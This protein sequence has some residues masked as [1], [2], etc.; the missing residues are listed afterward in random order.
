MH[1]STTRRQTIAALAVLVAFA[2]MGPCSAD[3]GTDDVALGALVNGPQRSEKNRARDR[4]RHPLES[5][6]FV[7]VEPGHTVIEI[8]PGSGGFWTEILAPY[9]RERGRYVAAI[10]A[11][12]TASPEGRK[13]N[14]ALR[15]KLAGSPALYDRV[16][17]AELDPKGTLAV[18]PGSADV[19]LTFR[20]VHNWMAEGTADAVFATF[21]AA[22]KPGGILAIEE[23]RG[24]TDQPQDPLAKSGYVREDYTIGLAE[25]AGFRLVGRSEVNANPRDTKDYPVGVWA[26][27]PTY[28]LKDQGREKYAAIGESDRFLLK[29]QKPGP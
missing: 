13:D 23:H 14:E 10:P 12:A 26:L 28:R 6:A 3:A 1:S 22:L 29:F 17:I 16:E 9:L 4:Y 27:P 20:N 15:A 21:F 18:S 11:E 5:L 25:A 19:V 2:V 8:Y 24:R 7:G